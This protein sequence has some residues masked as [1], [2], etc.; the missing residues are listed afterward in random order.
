METLWSGKERTLLGFGTALVAMQ[1]VSG[2]LVLM[3]SAF[4]A[5]ETGCQAR[6]A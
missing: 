2:G 6:T 4:F 5:P 3:P 1:P